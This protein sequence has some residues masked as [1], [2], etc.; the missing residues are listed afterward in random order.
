MSSTA[1]KRV[2][3]NFKEHCDFDCPSWGH[4]HFTS[5]L[6]RTDQFQCWFHDQNQMRKAPGLGQNKKTASFEPEWL[7]FSCNFPALGGWNSHDIKLTS[8]RQQFSDTYNV[9]QPSLLSSSQTS[10]T[11]KGNPVSIK[12]LLPI[13]LPKAPGNHQSALSLSVSMGLS[14]LGISIKWNHVICD[15]LFLFFFFF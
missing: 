2:N 1:K 9:V 13:P 14:I 12:L 5:D 15:F 10:I 3:K 4:L 7:G 6:S 11:L 8:E